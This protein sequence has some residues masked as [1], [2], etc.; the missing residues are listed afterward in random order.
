MMAGIGAGTAFGELVLFALVFARL[1]DFRAILAYQVNKV[2]IACHEGGCQAAEIAAVGIQREAAGETTAFR[3]LA[4]GGGTAFAGFG[5][6]QAG[7]DAG[8][9]G[10]S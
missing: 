6:G 7:V 3:F 4:A 2:A 1:A 8:L 10:F 9:M 5:A